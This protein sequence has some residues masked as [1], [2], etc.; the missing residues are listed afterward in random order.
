MQCD[1]IISNMVYSIGLICWYVFTSMCGYIYILLVYIFL[2][3]K[4]LFFNVMCILVFCAFFPSICCKT[5]PIIHLSNFFQQRIQHTIFGLR[6]IKKNESYIYAASPH[7]IVP[8]CSPCLFH[9]LQAKKYTLYYLVADILSKIPFINIFF[10]LTGYGSVRKD[11][12]KK[13]LQQG[14]SIYFQPGGFQDMFL[15]EENTL[16]KE[17]ISIP[18]GWIKYALQYGKKVI[19]IYNFDETRIS[20]FASLPCLA[21]RKKLYKQ[22]R[23]N[24]FYIFTVSPVF[25]YKVLCEDGITS[26]I[27]RPIT[28]PTISNPSTRD[29][30]KWHKKY[31]KRLLHLV[32]KYKI[33][34]G[35]PYLQ[36]CIKELEETNL[37][38]SS[39]GMVPPSSSSM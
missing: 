29:I 20:S 21:F 32:N 36:L 11:L 34:A 30:K 18:F 7:G 2:K 9:R 22:F 6:N 8:I 14:K 16:H 13:Q 25:L 3:N 37:F 12:F 19:P 28:F 10:R 26:A 38:C 24:P 23:M 39:P 5:R 1:Q 4:R 17:T 35:Y 33:K 31:C 27:G 15:C